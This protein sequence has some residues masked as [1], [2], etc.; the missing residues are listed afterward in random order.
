MYRLWLSGLYG[1]YA[2]R[3]PLFPKR[4]INLISLSLSHQSP[5]DAIISPRSKDSY[6]RPP[7]KP[8]WR[9]SQ[10]SSYKPKQSSS[11]KGQLSNKDKKPYSQS[12]VRPDPS[13]KKG[14]AAVEISVNRM[15]SLPVKRKVALYQARWQEIFPQFPEIIQKISQGI[16]IAF[17]DDARQFFIVL[18]SCTATTSHQT[19]FKLWRSSWTPKL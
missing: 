19:F 10:K 13:T 9:D 11:S 2:P 16:L 1:L 5:L 8:F 12:N 3:C 14:G 6:Q 18:W 15:D 4:P 17:S 7:G